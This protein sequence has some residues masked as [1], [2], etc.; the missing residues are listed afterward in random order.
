[1]PLVGTD[2]CYYDDSNCDINPY[3]NDVMN[4]DYECNY[5][6]PTPDFISKTSIFNIPPP[7]DLIKRQYIYKTK[8]G[9]RF[10][11]DHPLPQGFPIDLY[12]IIQENIQNE[13]EILEDEHNRPEDLF[14][15]GGVA[16]CPFV[17]FWMWKKLHET[18]PKFADKILHFTMGAFTVWGA[19]L[20]AAL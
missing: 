15:Y 13:P 18:H 10:R 3:G 9:K 16:I 5:T 11:F 7:S 1:M 19:I 6:I 4:D 2:Y 12:D 8:A 14:Y 20:F 17:G